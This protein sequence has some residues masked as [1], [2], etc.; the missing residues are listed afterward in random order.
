MFVKQDLTLTRGTRYVK[1]CYQNIKHH[2]GA[3]THMVSTKRRLFHS[4]GMNNTL[5]KIN[6][7][8]SVRNN[9]N[10]NTH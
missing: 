10:E 3:S 1:A 5:D 2:F 7:V 9:P 4:C 8:Q 6:A